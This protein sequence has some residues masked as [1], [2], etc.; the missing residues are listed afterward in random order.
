LNIDGNGDVW[1]GNAFDR[2]VVL[3]SGDETKGH[4]EGNQ[5]GDL[6]HVFEGGSIQIIAIDP[7]GQRLGREQL[8]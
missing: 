2:S 8:E 7:A 3:T 1:V 4:P 5:T 6:I